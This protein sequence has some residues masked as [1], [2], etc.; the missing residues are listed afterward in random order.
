MA[1][2]YE[3]DSESLAQALN[4]IAA[5]IDRS[6]SDPQLMVNLLNEIIE[7]AEAGKGDY[8]DNLIASQKAELAAL[9]ATSA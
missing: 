6:E 4:E 3:P 5:L 9:R 2:K 8:C 1:D 7:A